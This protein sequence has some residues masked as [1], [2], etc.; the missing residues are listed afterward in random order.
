M[1]GA[2]EGRITQDSLMNLIAVSNTVEGYNFGDKVCI[3]I[4]KED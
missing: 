4:L 2:V 3:I 1:K